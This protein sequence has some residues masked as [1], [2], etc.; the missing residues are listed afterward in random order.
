[1]LHS[2][3]RQAHPGINPGKTPRAYFYSRV[4]PS[5]AQ[6]MAEPASKRASYADVLVA[7]PNL[8]AEVIDGALH[9]Q[10][11]PR[12]RHALAASSLGARL[13]GLGRAGAGPADGW[14]ILYEPELHLGAEPDIVVPDLA[15]WRGQRIAEVSWDAAFVTQAPDWVC[16][17]AS[18]ATKAFDRIVKLPLYAREGVGHVWLLDPAE[19]LLEVFEL[20]AGRWVMAQ[21][22]SGDGA[23]RAQ[24][25]A[26]L[27]IVLASLWTP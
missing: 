21:V 17:I 1:M 11:R 26:E 22:F 24:P 23:V 15:G 20:S 2:T 6:L 9:T 10:P 12:L 3:Q 4:R 14:V 8:V 19:K 18:P 25:F 16:G 5:Y 13:Y 7:P 27:E